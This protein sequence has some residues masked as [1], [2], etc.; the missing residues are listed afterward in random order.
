MLLIMECIVACII[1]TIIILPAPAQYH[2]PLSQF[3]SY[4]TAIKKES[5]NYLNIKILLVK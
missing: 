4:P 1:F 2:N 5:I 3:A